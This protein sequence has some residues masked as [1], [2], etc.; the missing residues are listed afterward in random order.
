M[1]HDKTEILEAAI[2]SQKSI[3]HDLEQRTKDVLATDGNVNEEQYDSTEQ[4][5]KSSL[6]DEAEML[7]DELEFVK[8]ELIDL[9]KLKKHHELVTT[10]GPGAVVATN[11]GVYFV[12]VS[13]E[14][15]NVGKSHFFGISTRSPLYKKMRGKKIGDKFKFGK[16]EYQIKNIY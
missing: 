9:E 4:S 16:T 6:V 15:F 2:A 7:R 11:H 12:S 5:I 3:I 10:V 1:S 8:N 14:G 13:I